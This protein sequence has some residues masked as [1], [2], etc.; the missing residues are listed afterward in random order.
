MELASE[1]VIGTGALIVG[2][3]MLWVGMPNKSG[4]NPRFLRLGFMQMTYPAIVLMFFVIGVAELLKAWFS[5]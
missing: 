3:A 1:L 2:F 4:Q 5:T